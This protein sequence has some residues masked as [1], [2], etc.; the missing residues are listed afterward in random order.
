[1]YYH[2]LNN[3]TQVLLR[4]SVQQ[5]THIE[6]QI[7]EYTLL[8]VEIDNHIKTCIKCKEREYEG[9]KPNPED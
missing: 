2:I 5:V 9:S 7:D 4:S 6:L 1:M 3:N 8:F